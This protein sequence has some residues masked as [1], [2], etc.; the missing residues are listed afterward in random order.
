MPELSAPVERVH[1]SFLAAMAEFQAEGRG[2][3]A[4]ATM[5]GH[6]IRGFGSRWARPAAFAEYVGALRAQALEDTP[7]PAGFVPS[8]TLWWVEDDRCDVTNVASRRVIEANGGV[9]DDQR[10]VK[11]R[12]WV[13]TS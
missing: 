13:P 1:D 7:R 2:D 6:E 12:F 10:G 4:D 5:I 9:F 3:P 8:T 11:L